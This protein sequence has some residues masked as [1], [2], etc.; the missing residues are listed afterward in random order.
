MTLDKLPKFKVGD[1][2]KTKTSKY[3]YTI[4]DVRKDSYIMYYGNDKFAY[5]VPFRNEDEFDLIPNKF[6]IN[7]LKPF[8]KVLARMCNTD[9]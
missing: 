2:V 7:T 9:I 5:H 1:R 6:D 4:G 8:D 3:R